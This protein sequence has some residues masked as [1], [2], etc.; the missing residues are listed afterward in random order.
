METT[1]RIFSIADEADF[2]ALAL[3]TF[4]F[5]AE[6]CAP[7]REYLDLLETDP[8]EVRSTAEIPR[9]PIEVFKH[10]EVYCGEQAP[11]VVFTSSSTTG[12]GVSRHP[13]PS[14]AL[15][16]RAFTET[17]RRFYGDPARWSLYGL[18]PSYLEREGSSLVYM[19]DRLI[20]ACGSGGFYL[21]DHEALLRDMTADPKP[22][23]LLGVSYALWDL[24]EERPPK[25]ENTVVMETGGMKGRREE[26]PKEEFHRLLCD[27]LGVGAIHSEYGMAELTSQ[28]YSSGRNL[29]RTPPW[30]RVTARDVNDPFRT[31]P[32]GTRGGLDI[33]DLSNRFSCAFIQTQDV[34]RTF[35]DGS[36]TV[37]GR[38]DH[39]DIRGCNL[40]IQ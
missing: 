34:G 10:R 2:E 12:Q 26:L 13:M 22:K 32:T 30:M 33:I 40:L 36:F 20:R 24:A 8:D 25:L 4:R 23:I 21:R 27:G 37:E 17:F 18:L 7:Y 15:Y 29:F 3:E 19:V 28:A 14:L 1:E 31:L 38:I 39:A 35:A 11:E 6:R 5:Q 9:L 16:E